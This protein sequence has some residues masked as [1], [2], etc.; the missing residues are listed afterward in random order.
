[1]TEKTEQKLMTSPKTFSM[2]TADTDTFPVKRKTSK[3]NA[4]YKTIE[5]DSEKS[6]SNE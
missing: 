2:I 5:F 6:I 3:I 4:S 1:M